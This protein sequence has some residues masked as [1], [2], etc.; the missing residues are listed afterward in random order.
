MPGADVATM[1]WSACE[2]HFFVVYETFIFSLYGHTYSKSMDQ[3]G[4]V[5]NSVV[6]SC[7]GKTNIS[8]SAF[9]SENLVS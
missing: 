6:V 9:V 3:P 1:I 5:A 8:L 2:R 7:T 4:K